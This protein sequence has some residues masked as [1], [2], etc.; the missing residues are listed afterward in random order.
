MNREPFS[1]VNAL[2]DD[3]PTLWLMLTFA[4]SMEHAGDETAIAQAQADE[5]L[6][7]YVKHWGQQPG[8]LGIIARSAA[9]QALGAAWLRLGQKD[10][11]FKV[12]NSQVPELAIAVLP[13]AR[14]R[15]I[16]KAMM[17]HLIERAR[18]QFPAIVLSVREGNPATRFYENLG[19]CTTERMENRVGGASWVMR[20]DL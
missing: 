5:Y 3:E 10:G 18:G 20:L 4:A 6:R 12:S 11:P 14:D 2:P 16:G 19:F 15:G 13:E 1:L 9:G 17:R 7:G 8:D